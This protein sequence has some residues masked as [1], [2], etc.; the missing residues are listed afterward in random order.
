ML[1]SLLLIRQYF[2]K[3]YS[4][5][6]PMLITIC[7]LLD[8]TLFNVLHNQCFSC[9]FIEESYFVLHDWNGFKDILSK[10]I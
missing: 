8:V 1:L 10:G 9:E 2:A 3:I 7:A 4:I 6:A 5:E